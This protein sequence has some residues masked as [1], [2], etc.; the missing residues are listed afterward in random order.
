VILLVSIIHI[1]RHP[2]LSDEEKG[3]PK[4]YFIADTLAEMGCL[5][6]KAG[7][8][9]YQYDPASRARSS[10]SEVLKVIEAEAEKHGVTRCDLSDK[11][12]L[13]RLIFALIN[14]GFKVLEEGATQRPS[15]IDVV[16]VFGYGFPPY[17]GGPMFYTDT[18][19]LRK[20]Y[21]LLSEYREL[22]GAQYWSPSALLEEL[23]KDDKTLASGLRSNPSIF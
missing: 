18:V 17:R 9:Y 6:Q 12:I 23:V 11:E 1:R 13:N 2:A 19:G 3:D 5:G 20:V 15:D 16:Y 7:A 14:E 4:T 10:D 8:S 22:H 21:D